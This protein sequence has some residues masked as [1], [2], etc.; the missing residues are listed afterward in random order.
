LRRAEPDGDG[1]Q[2]APTLAVKFA[3]ILLLAGGLAAPAQTARRNIDSLHEFSGTLEALSKKIN[4]SVVQV[5]ASGYAMTEDRGDNPNTVTR[6]RASGSGVIVSA[7]GYIITN[8]H[9]V[10]NARKVRVRLPSARPS[11][12]SI[13]QPGGPIV[14]AKIVGVDKETDVALLKVSAQDLPALPFGDSDS[15]RQGELVMAFGSPM[16]MDNSMSLGVVSSNARQLK[17]DDAM[18]YVQTDASINPRN[19][20]GPLVDSDGVIVGINTFILSQSGGSEGLGFAIPSNIVKT[21]FAQLRDKGRV[22][23]SEI[24]VVTQSIN[25]GLAKALALPQDWGVLVADVFPDGPAAQAGLK[26][27]DIVLSLNGKPM[28]N[29]RQFDVNLYRYAMGQQVAL[30]V[31]RGKDKLTMN[32]AVLDR[33]DATMRFADLI[34]P[35]KSIVPKLGVMGIELDKRIAAMVAGLRKPYGVVVAARAGESP[36]AGDP[37]QLGDVIFSVNGTAVTTID[38]LNKAIDG[39]KEGDPLVLQVQRDEK[40]RYLTLEMQ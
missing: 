24:G 36:Y 3:L 14:E 11:G 35:A 34:D 10:S 21:V 4:R 18:I 25:P 9:V 16:G 20:G 17:A 32:V 19:S 40:L 26:V 28:E 8:G 15:L 5:F 37:L 30:E 39:L 1:S 12:G 6:Q 31:L 38:A 29:A 23:R 33:E 13:L 27:D 22:H 7:D 2:R